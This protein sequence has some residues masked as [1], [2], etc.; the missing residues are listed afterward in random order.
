MNEPTG[1]LAE[2][3]V[4]CVEHYHTADK[5]L[6]EAKYERDR[7]EYELMSEL[8]RHGDPNYVKPNWARINELMRSLR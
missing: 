2:V 6:M 7:R 1:A 4:G 3:F 5:A 8:M